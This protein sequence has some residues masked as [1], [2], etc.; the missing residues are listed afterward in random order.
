MGK[1]VWLKD[2]HHILRFPRR[3]HIIIFMDGARPMTSFSIFRSLSLFSISNSSFSL[4][5]SH[6]ASFLHRD[7][8][9]LPQKIEWEG[10]IRSRSPAAT[11][12]VTVAA[13]SRRHLP[14]THKHV[15]RENCLMVKVSCRLRSYLHGFSHLS[16]AF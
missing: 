11:V 6:V 5:R 9:F 10:T 7:K 13:S 15:S 4:S 12:P 2:S 16:H 1:L 14:S 3:Y 8:W